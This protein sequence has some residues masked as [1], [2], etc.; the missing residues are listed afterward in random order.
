[1]MNDQ[2]V[3]RLSGISFAGLALL[4]LAIPAGAFAQQPAGGRGQPGAQSARATAAS[5][6]TGT[7]VS[8]IT[9]EWTSRMVTPRKGDRRGG[10]ESGLRVTPEGVRL[11]NMWDPAKD[12]A[13]GEQCKGYGAVGVTRLPGKVRISW[14]DDNTLKVEF[15][16]GTQV[17][18]FHFGPVPPP[19]GPPTGQG[20]SVARWER[21]ELPRQREGNLAV[22]TTHLRPQYARKNGFPVSGNAKLTEYLHVL[23]APNGDLWLSLIGELDDP[24]YYL[25]PHHYSWQFKKVP[26]NSPWN[27]E[28][29]SAR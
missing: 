8:V 7:W 17:R 14:Q 12:E 29:C 19:K 9:E 11:A 24:L 15:E 25:D 23:K 1:M 16:A 18:L 2:G 28:P 20:H 3:Q 27:P 26:D 10:R 21:A 22:V 4:V 5:D 6:P 13:A